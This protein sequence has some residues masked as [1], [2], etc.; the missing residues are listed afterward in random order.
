M[1][2]REGT[3]VYATSEPARA[4]HERIAFCLKLHNDSVRAMRFPL[5]AHKKELA[6]ADEARERERELAKVRFRL[7]DPLLFADL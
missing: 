2:G 1:E 7:F 3:D 5:Q 4:F 6:S